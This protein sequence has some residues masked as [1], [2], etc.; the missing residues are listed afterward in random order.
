[1]RIVV[2]DIAASKG[3]ALTVLKDFYSCVRENDK[4]NEWIFLLGDNLLEET[5]TYGTLCDINIPSALLLKLQTKDSFTLTLTMKD[6]AGLS[7]YSR[8]SGRYGLGVVLKAQ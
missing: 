1:M 6:E 7:L 5:G 4:E 3:G 8:N 2:N